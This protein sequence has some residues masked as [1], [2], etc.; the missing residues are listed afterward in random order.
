MV[1]QRDFMKCIGLFC[2]FTHDA[3]AKKYIYIE[4]L[5]LLLSHVRVCCVELYENA[6]PELLVRQ[7]HLCAT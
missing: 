6:K 7:G 4:R 1:F 3:G 2:C 5:R